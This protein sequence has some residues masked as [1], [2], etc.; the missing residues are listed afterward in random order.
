MINSVSSR[1]LGF[2]STLEQLRAILKSPEAKKEGLRLSH[3]KTIPP[4]D[5]RDNPLGRRVRLFLTTDPKG[6]RANYNVKSGGGED[7][8]AF[9]RTVKEAF[10]KLA[11]ISDGVFVFTKKVKIG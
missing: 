7:L 6:S 5:M 8:F 9:G 3:Y 2:S 11:K 1:S 10:A 4:K